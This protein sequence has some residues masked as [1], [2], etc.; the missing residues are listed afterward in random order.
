[1]SEPKANM[2]FTGIATFAR[3]P[4]IPDLRQLSA[5]FAVYG[6]PFDCAVGYRPGQRLAPRAIRDMSTRF[7]MDW[8]AANPGFW[9]IETDRHYLKGCRLVDVG[10]VDPLYHDLEHLD[11][12]A[13]AL[14][15]GILAAGAV[16]VGIGGDHSV[17]YPMIKAFAGTG[18]L[19]IV[20]IDAHLDFTDQIH[21]FTRSNSSP[22]R[23][24][25][26]LPFVG[27]IAVQGVRGL[28]T[29]EAAYRAAVGRGSRVVLQRTIR[30]QGI[31][32]A[33]TAL[34]RG[35]RVYLTIDIDALDPS[36]APG[37]SSPEF[38]GMSLTELRQIL[39]AVAAQNKVVGIDLVEV[40][41]YLDVAN[42]TSNL[43]ARILVE[44]IAYAHAGVT[45]PGPASA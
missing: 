34:P 20:Q 23:R 14:V 11:R 18:D 27:E 4:Y 45:G 44:A 26:E 10:D 43:A 30:E 2:A 38:E 32:A 31:A 3:A 9:D 15:G 33:L 7:G 41:P 25:A 17:T 24:A 22:I 35:K 5:D 19:A 13:A 12:S 28:R 42:L 29:N 1:M 16:P 21:G 39:R 36:L 40:N 6:F 37:T 8:G